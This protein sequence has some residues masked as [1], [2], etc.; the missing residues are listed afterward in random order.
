VAAISYYIV[1]LF[2]YL[3]KPLDG[4]GLP[5]KAGT[6][7]AIFVPIAIG[8]TWMVVRSIRKGHDLEDKAEKPED[9]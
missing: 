5:I 3:A 1:G 8:F 2:G 7:S 6:A 4:L 9:T